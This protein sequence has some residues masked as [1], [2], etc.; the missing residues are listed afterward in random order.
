MKLGVFTAL[1]G[2][3]TLDEVLS[4]AVESGLEAVEL[5]SGNYPGAAH[6]DVDALLK[7]DARVKELKAK[8][9]DRG[10]VISALSCHG[11]PLHPDKAV[12]KEH[13]SVFEKSVR[14]AS[15]LGV[16]VVVGFSGCPG[17]TEKDKYPNWVTCPWPDDFSDIVKWQWEEK[18][19]PY[20]TKQNKFLKDHGVKFAIEMHPGFLVYNPETLLRLRKAAG[21]NIGTNFDPSHL[22][23]QG[24]DPIK[25]LRALKGTLYHVHAKDC[26]IDPLNADVNGVLDTKHYGDEINRSWIF[27]TVGYGHGLDFW[28]DFV[29]T[30][31]LLGYDDVVSIEHEDSL[32]SPA[33]GLGKAV[34][35]LKG[36]LLSQPRGA[37]TWA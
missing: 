21:S 8:I 35:F 27:R 34:A 17:G 23:W 29:S 30:L 22:F 36:V 13:H 20:W 26:I 14:L 28:T 15:K 31:R 33:E 19:V 16:K 3:K 18:A 37:M 32:M 10:L 1:F 12:A 11:N 6:I 7:S 24:M 2:D 5:G 25:S 9:V 4:Y